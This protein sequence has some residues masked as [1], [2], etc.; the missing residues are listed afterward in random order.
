MRVFRDKA[1]MGDLVG[2]M[3]VQVILNEEAGLLG[4]AVAAADAGRDA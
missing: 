3:P 2:D 1:P 4:A